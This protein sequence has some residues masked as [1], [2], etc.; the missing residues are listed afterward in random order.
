MAEL[1]GSYGR[2]TC[3]SAADT[4]IEPCFA[5]EVLGS[6]ITASRC[7]GDVLG[8]ELDHIDRSRMVSIGVNDLFGVTKIPDL[9]CPILTS[10]KQH[11]GIGRDLHRR[12]MLLMTLQCSSTVL[13]PQIPQLDV[14]VVAATGQLPFL[15]RKRRERRHRCGV[16]LERERYYLNQRV[17]LEVAISQ[18]LMMPRLLPEI[19]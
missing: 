14:G 19:S 15:R 5:S 12:N 8:V 11:F 9:G 16:P 18:I 17:L 2:S 1:N 13:R 4:P 10:G 6:F 7:E 3:L